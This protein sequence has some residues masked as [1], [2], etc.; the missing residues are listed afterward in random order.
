MR[1]ESPYLLCDLFGK[2]TLFTGGICGKAHLA[3]TILPT[4][5]NQTETCV[6]HGR[7]KPLPLT[8]VFIFDLKISLPQTQIHIWRKNYFKFKGRVFA[9]PIFRKE[10]GGLLR[11]L[12]FNAPAIFVTHH[13]VRITRKD[14]GFNLISVPPRSK[15]F[16]EQ[17][18]PN[19][20]SFF[21]LSTRRIY[22]KEIITY[23]KK[24][25]TRIF[26]QI[27]VIASV[28]FHNYFGF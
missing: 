26:F 28:V 2:Y 12:F 5:N 7:K 23:P 8:R 14:D 1:S 13:R 18:I 3:I 19:P 25:T 22:R 4:R 11:P 24:S 21:L 10:L 9:A 17:G 27:K 16:T 6:Y 15:P 20:L